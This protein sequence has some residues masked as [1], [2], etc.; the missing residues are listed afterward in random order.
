MA[1]FEV[2]TEA[3]KVRRDGRVTV[4][5]EARD[6]AFRRLPVVNDLDRDR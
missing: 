2:I 4:K 6:R 5:Q 3:L 1:G